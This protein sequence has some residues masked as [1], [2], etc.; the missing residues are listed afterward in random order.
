M[1]SRRSVGEMGQS[2][3]P[4]IDEDYT[5]SVLSAFQGRL[6][7]DIARILAGDDSADVVLQDGDRLYTPK[8]VESI[9]VTGEVYEPGS[10]R[11]QSD[12]NYVDYLELAAGATDRARKKD[13]YLIKPDGAVVSL[14][15]SRKNLFKFERTMT[16]IEPGSVIVVPTN[17]DYVKFS[18]R[19]RAVTSIVFE[20][21]T[22]I[23]AFFSIA[24]K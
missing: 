20:S 2:I 14:G 3:A 17:Y 13:I 5:K 4:S 6:V 15:K 21:A 18:E 7:I 19:A 10:F 16:G 11:F 23:A 22:S 9:T 1:A 24:N 12:L 8:L